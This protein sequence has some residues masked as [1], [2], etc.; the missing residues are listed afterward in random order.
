MHI[1][2]GVEGI[3]HDGFVTSFLQVFM[4]HDEMFV[5][6]GAMTLC[7]THAL[8]VSIVRLLIHHLGTWDLQGYIIQS[9]RGNYFL[10]CHRS[11]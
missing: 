5:F 11:F 6:G 3:L 9:V 7:L 10:E 4:D 8:K 2:P 1:L